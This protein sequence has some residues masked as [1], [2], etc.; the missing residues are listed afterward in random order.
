LNLYQDSAYKYAMA[1]GDRRRIKRD[2]GSAYDGLATPNESFY[3]AGN[4]TSKREIDAGFMSDVLEDPSQ[5][6]STSQHHGLP[7][8][9]GQSGLAIEQRRRSLSGKF[10]TMPHRFPL[11]LIHSLRV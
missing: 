5:G 3:T 6:F 1:P 9:E 2:S 8:D 4:V 11:S 7:E 10:E